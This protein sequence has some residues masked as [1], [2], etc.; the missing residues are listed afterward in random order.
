MKFDKFLLGFSFST[1]QKPPQRDWGCFQDSFVFDYQGKTIGV[2]ARSKS[3][4]KSPKKCHSINPNVLL[5]CSSNHLRIFSYHWFSLRSQRKHARSSGWQ[6]SLVFR[7]AIY[8]HTICVTYST[9][10]RWFCLEE[11]F[12]RLRTESFLFR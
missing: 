8:E 3:P 5:F 12:R 2:V 6:R 11:S 9:K 10:L 1:W 7:N 4:N